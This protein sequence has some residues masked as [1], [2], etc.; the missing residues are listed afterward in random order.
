MGYLDNVSWQKIKKELQNELEKSLAVIKSRVNDIQKK[1]EEL[2]EEG[3]RQYKIMSTKAK[4]HDA[5]RDL[6]S[7]VYM[8]VSESGVKNPALDAGVKD[9]I[10]GIK[11]LEVELANLEAKADTASD[12]VTSQPSVVA[13]PKVRRKGQVA[14]R[15]T[16]SRR[17]KLKD[18]K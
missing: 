17:A 12:K 7:K 8:L 1:A 13:H 15:T 10:A 5:M 4:I 6:G 3:K 9:V 16:A 18:K 2:T 14:A 11:S